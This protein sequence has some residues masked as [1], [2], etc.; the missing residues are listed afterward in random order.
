MGQW[1]SAG[2]HREGSY[3]TTQ[4]GAGGHLLQ[5]GEGESGSG[6]RTLKDLLVN[7]SVKFFFLGGQVM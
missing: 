4:A 1:R 7:L 3:S 2:R 6:S 5:G